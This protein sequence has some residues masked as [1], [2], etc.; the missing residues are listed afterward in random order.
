MNISNETK[1]AI[2]ILAAI[3]LGYAGYRLMSD[4]PVF[5]KAK[6]VHTHFKQT[7]G[8]NTGSYVYIS[9]VKV[10]SVKKIKLTKDDSVRVTLGFDL[11]M[12]I[13]NDS[14]AYLESSGPLDGKRIV[15]RRGSSKQKLAYG[16]KIEG[17][18]SGG[19]MET[20]KEKGSQLSEDASESMQKINKLVTRLNSVVDSKSQEDIKGTISNLKSS[21]DELAGLMDDKRD[22]LSGS[23]DHAKRVLAN[24]DTVTSNN[25]SRIDSVMAGVDASVND[26]E[27]LSKNLNKTNKNLN[28]ILSKINN[29]KGSL[30]KLVND[31]GL[32]N[33]LESMSAGV[34]TLIS[35][36]N[37]NPQKYLKGLRLID[38]F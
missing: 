33:N 19:M 26:L 3:V 11:D 7:N 28:Q 5:R 36:I 30:G 24:V 21:T 9:G 8:L 1:V 20:L 16:D 29:G 14:K 4:L 38:I 17:V 32:Y 6:T 18:Y 34:D 27:V 12:D 22:E 25:K 13:P 37:K 10:G 35:N 2:T 15:V 31:P 23:I